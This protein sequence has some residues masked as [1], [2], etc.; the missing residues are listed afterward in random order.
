ML[1]LGATLSAQAVA[2]HHMMRKMPMHDGMQKA[3]PG[4]DAIMYGAELMAQQECMEH[5][6]RMRA[7]KTD[8]EREAFRLEYHTLMQERAKAMGK[9]L[10]DMPPK[11]MEPGSG[12]GPSP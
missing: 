6:A 3:M 11:G 2:D 8:K 7:L 5:Q 10:P 9:T 12:L 1:A 4:D